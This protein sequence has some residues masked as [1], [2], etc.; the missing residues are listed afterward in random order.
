MDVGFED[1]LRVLKVWMG[2]EVRRMNW[3]V[4]RQRDRADIG[5]IL[6]EGR[7]GVKQ[8]YGGLISRSLASASKDTRGPKYMRDQSNQG[9]LI[10]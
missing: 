8:G 3:Q 4:W 1:D 2:H 7:G 10:V 9:R 5:P 6:K